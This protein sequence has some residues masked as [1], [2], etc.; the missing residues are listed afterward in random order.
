MTEQNKTDL[1]TL[2]GQADA[3]GVEYAN[4]VTIAKLKKL[5]A[6]HLTED[7]KEVA[8]QELEDL[9][10]EKLKLVKIIVTPIDSAKR[11]HEGEIFA[12]GNDVLGTIKRF[13]PFNQEWLVENI[14]AQH[15]KSREF[16]YMQNKKDKATG[17]DYVES[18]I[19]NAFNVQELPLP[20][21]AEI[22]ELA[23]IQSVKDI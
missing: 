21:K 20:T 2:K 4:N 11:D 9:K 6:E 7:N 22:E 16:Q 17:R 15:I 5:I 3:L 10:A 12:V 14:L 23:K 13:V 18:K 19:I 8:V 1:E